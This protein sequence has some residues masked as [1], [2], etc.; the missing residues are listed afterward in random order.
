MLT[1]RWER[2]R[3]L[4]PS[5]S[6]IP[7]DDVYLVF[8]FTCPCQYPKFKST[9]I[10]KLKRASI[11]DLPADMFS[12]M[13]ALTL[14]F[15][16]T[17]WTP[18]SMAKLISKLTELKM[19]QRYRAFKVLIQ[20]RGVP[21]PEDLVMSYATWSVSGAWYWYK[22]SDTL[23]LNR[24]TMIE[25]KRPFNT[26]CPICLLEDEDVVL[27]LPC[28]HMFHFHCIVPWAKK[29]NICPTCRSRMPE[30]YPHQKL[31]SNHS[32]HRRLNS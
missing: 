14:L 30:F 29:S 2:V 17:T 25:R 3:A 8:T 9:F 31:R 11:T 4:P 12:Q 28:K 7:P 24:K 26:E 19:K 23:V 13:L 20:L 6:D 27:T 15:G 22:N 18:A 16:P 10:F 32:L 1:A 21:H 5:S